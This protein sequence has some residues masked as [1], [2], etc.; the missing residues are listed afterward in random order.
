M[1]TLNKILKQ[2]GQ[3]YSPHKQLF[4]S[5]NLDYRLYFILPFLIAEAIGAQYFLQTNKEFLSIV[6]FVSFLFTTLGASF[7]HFKYIEK[8]YGSVESLDKKRLNDFIKLV[9]ENYKIDLTKNDQN[10]LIES[11]VKEKIESNHKKEQA[12]NAVN[13]A[14][15]SITIPLLSQYIFPGQEQTLIMTSMIMAAGFILLFFS[16]KYL[17]KE[18][19]MNSKLK[20]IN[21][22]LKEIR[23]FQMTEQ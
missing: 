22:L 6:L 11:I 18:Y 1:N 12:K 2:H 21:D 14:I 10:L 4:Q 23:L 19:T 15:L 8:I 16:F 13:L 7:W 20:H 17:F 5:L 3:V 9:K